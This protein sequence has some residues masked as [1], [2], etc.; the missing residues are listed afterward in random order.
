[1][2]TER[3]YLADLLNAKIV[4]SFQGYDLVTSVWA[5]TIT[6]KKFGI[7][8]R[9]HLLGQDLWQGAA[10]ADARLTSRTL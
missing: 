10:G 3:M 1:M 4:V 6:T 5:K 9:V 7:R 2:A 8:Q